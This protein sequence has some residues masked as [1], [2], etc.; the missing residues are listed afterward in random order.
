MTDTCFICVNSFNQSTRK[1]IKCPYCDFSAC[2]TCC[3][4][5]VL[6]ESTVKCMSNTCDREWTRQFITNTFTAV[7]INGKL[8]K[9]REQVL[10][11]NERALLP[12][13][14]PLVERNIK[15]EKTEKELYDIQRKMRE[16]TI[17]KHTTTAELWRL[18][19]RNAPVERAEFVR[20]CPDNNCRGFLSTQW[21]CGICEQW[22]CPDC[23]EIKGRNRDIAH[24]CNPDTL[25]T[26][27]LLAN[28]TK[29]CPNCRTGI[30]KIDGCFAK[31]TTI[32]LW[33]GSIKKSQD[34]CLGDIL[35][36]DNGERRIVERLFSGEDELFEVTQAN[37]EKYIVNSKHTLAL[38]FIGNNV[39]IWNETSNSW[40]L[41]WFD[42]NEKRNKIKSFK[43]TDTCSKENSEILANS[44]IKSLHLE[45]VIQITVEDYLKLD[46]WS[47]KYLYGFKSCNGVNYETI[48]V[49]LDPYMLGLWLGDGTHTHPV[50]A[51]NDKEIEDYINNWCKHNDAELVK[52]DKYKL[53]IRRKGYTFGKETVDGTIYSENQTLLHKTNPF[54]EELKKYNLLGNKHI[55]SEYLMNDRDNRLKLLAGIIDTDGHVAKNQK[56]KRVVIIQTS[57]VLS[58][59]I[60]YLA[61]SLGF[62]VNF[63][64]RERKNVKI[65]DCE[66]K[67]YKDQYV[68]N[69]SGERLNEIPTILPRKKCCS[70]NTNKDYFRTSIQV[71]SIGKGS[72]YG[73]LVNENN[74]FVLEDFTVVKNCDQMF[75][76]SCNTGFNWR[77]GRIETNIHNPHYFEWLR[78]NGNNVPRN[79][80]DVPCRNDI[81]HQNFVDIRN[82]L[83]SANN[84]V[85]PLSKVCET[86]LEKV[87][88]NAIHLRYVI[89]PRYDT[90]NRINRNEH[91]R[92]QFMRNRITETDFKITLQR[93]Q[94]KIEKYT[95]IHN[96]LEILLT[97]ITEIVFRFINNLRQCE[98]GNWEMSILEEIDPIVDYVNGCL[99][100]ISKTYSST[101]IR[102]SNEI[103]E[104]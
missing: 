9:H 6:G 87:V 44:Y 8:K 103:R 47:K 101:F 57:P 79:P 45:D 86:F 54:I 42:T 81:N 52:E 35:I 58:K 2:K 67:D 15:I 37:A 94:K 30:F 73:W 16:L 95:E 22:A 74:R 66:I 92:I 56:G 13:T 102:F 25:A 104:I 7:F 98:N 68:I 40:K 99:K 11:D 96:V 41:N 26:A 65:F 83:R 59:Q 36:G 20:A 93:N 70:S 4:T 91:L 82:L 75:C 62:L 3:E 50:I 39:P 14:Q 43:V 34:I 61:K 46:K 18:R 53:R 69:I 29:P 76:T 89:L 71:N 100:E 84:S 85:N 23:H 78:R 1:L 19:N 88:R 33:N 5:Y 72:Y 27:R 60:I 24:E 12:A 49:S 97:T 63:T 31:D 48:D 77:T 32:L 10:F 64:I 90:G 80:G 55:P 28:D 51:S 17:E 38:K 21:K